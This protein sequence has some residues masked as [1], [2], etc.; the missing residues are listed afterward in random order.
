MHFPSSSR[1]FLIQNSTF[2][3]SCIDNT[4]LECHRCQEGSILVF[5][6][7]DLSSNPGGVEVFFLSVPREA[8][9]SS[10]LNG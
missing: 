2:N 9:M 7:G 8:K 1:I 4:I 3:T 6:P 5:G 10:S